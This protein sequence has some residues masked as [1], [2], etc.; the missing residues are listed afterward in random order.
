MNA[1]TAFVLAGV[2]ARLLGAIPSPADADQSL[3][4]Y[5]STHIAHW[6]QQISIGDPMMIVG[7]LISVRVVLW[8]DHGDSGIGSGYF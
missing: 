6:G 5:I 7:L 1:I 3:G 8:G 4:S 2:V